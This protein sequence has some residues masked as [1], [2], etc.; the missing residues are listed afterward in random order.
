MIYNYQGNLVEDADEHI[1]LALQEYNKHCLK[2][3]YQYVCHKT[4]IED[5]P[6]KCGHESTYKLVWRPADS[7]NGTCAD[8][9]LFI[10]NDVGKCPDCGSL[11]I[12]MK[13]K[14]I[15]KWR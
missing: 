2:C 11:N 8:C 6:K 12:K 3:F 7:G 15:K 1:E 9:G 13:W 14:M 10:I 4:V 5:I